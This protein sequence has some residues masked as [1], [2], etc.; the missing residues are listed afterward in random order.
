M[1]AHIGHTCRPSVV[2][3]QR[4][5]NIAVIAL[6]RVREVLGTRPNIVRLQIDGIRMMICADA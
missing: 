2:V 3:P 6:E 5:Q 4:E 1:G